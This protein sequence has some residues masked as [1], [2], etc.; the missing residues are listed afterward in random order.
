MSQ[1]SILLG[2]G[3]WLVALAAMGSSVSAQQGALADGGRDCQTVRV[4]QFRKGG[5]YRGCISAYSCR[6][7]QLVRQNC[8]VGDR[9][10]NCY[11]LR[12]SW[13]A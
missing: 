6:T 11:E 5:S 4:C 9:R 3:A 7:C 1:R 10:R 12:C 8:R 2:L 13:G